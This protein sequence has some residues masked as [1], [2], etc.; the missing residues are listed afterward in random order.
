M[1][2]NYKLWIETTEKF[3]GEGPQQLLLL[4]DQTGSLNIASKKMNLSYK[5]ALT[6]IKRAEDQLG[7]KLLER[8]IGGASG[9]GSRLTAEARHWIALFERLNQRLE[10]AAKEEWQTICREK[11]A[12]A[13]IDPLKADLQVDNSAFISIIGGGGKTTLLN[14][15]WDY[16]QADYHTLYSTTTKV[17]ARADIKTYYQKAPPHQSVALY[18]SV[19]LADKVSGVPA[20]QLNQLYRQGAYHLILCEADGSRGLP[21]KLHAEHEP[22]IPSETTHL[23]I[24]I[25]CDAF[26]LPIKDAVHRYSLYDLKPEKTL[27]IAWAIDYL[28]RAIISKIS[29]KIKVNIVFNKFSKYPLPEDIMTIERHLVGCQQSL[30]I[31]TADLAD[32]K[33]YHFVKI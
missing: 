23:Y 27:D 10:R 17:K 18:D 22:V 29:P 11:F 12:Q 33:C 16:F 9:G 24:V 20:E 19:V 6:I 26:C 15:F 30:A 14:L 4:T 8:K 3:Y 21:F 28:K 5:K 25:G 7:F 2:V 31:F 13:F 1:Q 32:E